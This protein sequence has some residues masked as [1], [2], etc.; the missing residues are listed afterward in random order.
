MYNVRKI[1]IGQTM[2][3]LLIALLTLTTLAGCSRFVEYDGPQVTR[4][5]VDKTERLMFLM[6]GDEVLESYEVELGFAPE[7]HK[8]EEGDGR[9]P[10]GEYII[11]RR[12]PNSQW[13]LSIGISYPNA[14]DIAQARARGVSPGGE[15]FIHGTTRP[16]QGQTDWTAGC[17]AVTNREM[18]QIYAM[19]GNGTPITILP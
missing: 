15:I 13:Y 1:K 19:V 9:T 10:E 14:N 18:R 4:I 6:H 8:L 12:N 17:I 3:I 11:D 16:F 7:G 5:I 2:R